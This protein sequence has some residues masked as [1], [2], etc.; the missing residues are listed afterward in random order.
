M[1]T[2]SIVSKFGIEINEKDGKKLWS[3]A[4]YR[5]PRL[6]QI[7]WVSPSGPAKSFPKLNNFPPPRVKNTK[8]VPFPLGSRGVPGG[9]QRRN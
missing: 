4:I 8:T 3:G 2:H 5:W 9:G 1:S 7:P 6:E